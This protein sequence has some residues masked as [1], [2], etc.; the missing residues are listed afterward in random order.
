MQVAAANIL[1]AGRTQYLVVTLTNAGGQ[2]CLVTVDNS[3]VSLRVTMEGEH[4]YSTTDCPDWIPSQE[5]AELALGVSRTLDL[6]WPGK[7]SISQ[8]QLADDVLGAGTYVIAVTY[9]DVTGS[10]VTTLSAA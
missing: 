1:I 3:S 9:R 6:S 7:R 5:P 2:P 8:C 4:V 10:L